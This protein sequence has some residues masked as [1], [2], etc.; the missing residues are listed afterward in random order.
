MWFSC[1]KSYCFFEQKTFKHIFAFVLMCAYQKEHMK[2]VID[3]VSFAL[4]MV[5]PGC[6]A[7][8]WNCQDRNRQSMQRVQNT[9]SIE[10]GLCLYTLTQMY[11]SK[12]PFP[13]FCSLEITKGSQ[14][15]TAKPASRAVEPVS[16]FNLRSSSGHLN[17]LASAPKPFGPI[18]SKNVQL[19]D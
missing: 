16:N 9:W 19:F 15:L 6:A 13:C 3:C 8:S 14:A 18:K 12:L 5:C 4:C 11:F 1:W 7:V 17:F 2:E 10:T